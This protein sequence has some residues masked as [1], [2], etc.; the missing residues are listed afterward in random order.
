MTVSLIVIAHNEAKH[1]KAC[2]E[3]LVSQSLQPQEIIVV[4][5][6]CTDETVHLAEQFKTMRVLNFTGPAGQPYAREAGIAQASGTIIAC[7]DGD[8]TYQHN[9]LAELVKPFS[10]PRI[11]GAGSVVWLSGLVGAW[12]SFDYFYLTPLTRFWRKLYFWGASM[13][14]RKEDF[15]RVGGFSKL[16]DLKTKL[17][18]KNFAEDL[19]LAELLTQK[20]SIYI[21]RRTYAYSHSPQLSLLA[22]LSRA[23]DQKYDYI[24]LTEYFKNISHDKSGNIISS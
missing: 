1:I 20:G 22:W 10:D 12:M 24:K 13:A 8:T 6:N 4:A 15:L 17:G 23:K 2:L 14:F 7:A 9:W 21:T 16:Y 11:T 5:H 3:S 18:L 19:Y